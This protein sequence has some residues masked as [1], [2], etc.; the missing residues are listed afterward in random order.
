MKKILVISLILIMW[1]FANYSYADIYKYVDEDGVIHLTNI[2]K[3]NHY[4]KII[5][6]NVIHRQT[7]YNQLIRSASFKYGIEPSLIK[8]LITVESNW[9][10]SAVSKK[11]AIGLMQIMPAT[12][13]DMK[14]INPYDP[15]QNIEAGTR[16]LRFMLDRFKGNL[17]LALAAY[18]AGPATVE[19]SGGVPAIAETRNYIKKVLSIH[20]KRLSKPT[21]R[22]Y[23]IV[24]DNGSILYTDNPSGI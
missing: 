4:K 14:I 24:N 16:Y 11:G 7:R 6:E 1:S 8:A 19:K 20:N 17:N 5:A 22:T 15:G 2:P 13:T 10:S 18:N 21:A 9:D 23:R 12:A 3:G